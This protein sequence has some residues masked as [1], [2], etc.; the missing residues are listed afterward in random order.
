MKRRVRATIGPLIAALAMGLALPTVLGCASAGIEP[1]RRYAEGESLPR[2]GVLLVYDFA[3]QSGDVV[4]D[5]FGPEFAAGSGD[6]SER[7]QLGREVARSLSEQLVAKLSERGIRAERA[8]PSRVPPLHAMVLKGQFVSID[9]GDQMKRMVIGL[10]AGSTELRARVQ[11]YQ[12][13][14]R[15]LRR[16]AEAEADASGSKTPGMAIPVGGGAAA[17]RAAS[18]AVISGGMNIV[19]EARGSLDAEAGRMAEKMA[20]RVKAFYK[21]QG[22][23]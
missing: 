21:R 6:R 3:V 23:L 12:A 4:V 7:Y 18:A 13:T 17:G 20:E 14:E 15:G 10:G 1:G 19:R 16:I 9:E 22:W 11:A 2:P 5:T 8:A